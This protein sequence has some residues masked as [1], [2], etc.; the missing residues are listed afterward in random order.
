MI[1][2][3][4]I[5]FKNIF[6]YFLIIFFILFLNQ[7]IIFSKIISNDILIYLIIFTIIYLLLKKL[8]NRL[9]IPV[10][11]VLLISSFFIISDRINIVDLN[12]N[13]YM[14][15]SLHK[16][17]DEESAYFGKNGFELSSELKYEIKEEYGAD[18]KEL[19]N[20]HI[21]QNKGTILDYVIIPNLKNNE[22]LLIKNSLNK[23]IESKFSINDIDYK[24]KIKKDK[25]ILLEELIKAESKFHNYK[26]I[27]EQHYKTNI[28]N[29]NIIKKTSYEIAN[30]FY[31]SC[32]SAK[33]YKYYNEVY[34][35]FSKMEIDFFLNPNFKKLYCNNYKLIELKENYY[36]IDKG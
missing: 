16:A 8:K 5:E 34:S 1:K 22:I 19:L 17:I 20:E 4:L 35:E 23:T 32:N 15:K 10:S 9:S 7:N 12:Y 13:N 24:I 11:I 30:K 3:I 6:L 27:I 21:N 26:Y 28:E 33:N 31:I 29:I 18:F 36:L 14:K 25:E 2:K